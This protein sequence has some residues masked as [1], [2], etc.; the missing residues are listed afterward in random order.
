[1]QGE[2]DFGTIDVGIDDEPQLISGTPQNGVWRLQIPIAQGTPPGTYDIQLWIEDQ[3]HFVSWFSPGHASDP[4][5]HVLT[6]ELAPNG[7]VITVQ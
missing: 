6:P 1:V 5:Q 4:S 2:S 7:A 3:T